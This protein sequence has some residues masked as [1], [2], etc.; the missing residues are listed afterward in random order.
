MRTNNSGTCFVWSPDRTKALIVTSCWNGFRTNLKVPSIYQD[1]ALA[2]VVSC[3]AVAKIRCL[4]SFTKTSAWK[5]PSGM[6]SSISWKSRSLGSS[7]RSLCRRRFAARAICSGLG[8]AGQRSSFTS[9]NKTWKKKRKVKM[10]II[11]LKLKLIVAR[12]RKLAVAL[13]LWPPILLRF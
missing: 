2:T 6:Q 4:L 3:S 7:G 9:L 13:L 5:N 10:F 1:L 12:E 11:F 8:S